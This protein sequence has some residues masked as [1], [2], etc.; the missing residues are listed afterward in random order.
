MGQLQNLVPGH[1]AMWPQL[2]VLPN[3]ATF[4]YR[5]VTLP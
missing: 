5:H 4:S 1:Q 2:S 3:K